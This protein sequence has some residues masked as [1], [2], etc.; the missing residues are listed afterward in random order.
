[1]L[2]IISNEKKMGKEENSYKSIMKRISA[3][4]G[5]QLLNI[6][7]TLVRGKFVAIFLG[8][9]GMG[10]SSLYT[11]SSNTIQQIGSLGLNLA[12]VKEV[13]ASKDDADKLPHILAVAL[14]L[15]LLSSLFGAAICFLLS[16][17]LSRWTFGDSTHTSGFMFLSVAVALATGG[18]GLLSILQGIGAVKELSKASLVGGICGL[19]FGVP[20][21]YFFGT[22]GIVPAMILLFL[23]MFIFYGLSLKK[24]IPRHRITFNWH[25]HSPLVRKIIAIGLILLI[26]NLA[27]TLTGYI[28]NAFIRYAGGLADVGLFQAANSITNQYMGVVLSALALDY[29]PRLSA[30]AEDLREMRDIVNRQTE[31]VSLI[32]APLVLLLMASAPIVIYLLLSSE[33]M[34]VMPLMRWMGFGMVFQTLNFPLGYIFI[35]KEDK[36]VYVWLEV[37]LSNILWILTSIGCYYWFGLIGLGVSLVARA[38]IELPIAYLVARKRYGYSYD[39]HTLLTILL[40]VSIAAAG[41][42][43]SFLPEIYAYI[44]MSLLTLTSAIYSFLKI[45]KKLKAEKES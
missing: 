6:F 4:G 14:R 7:L 17:L 9:A 15:I 24:Y 19:L 28:I 29:F 3:F 10:V 32:I 25:L 8:P 39:R 21:Y 40:T 20:L 16:P 37:V 23:S 13:A 18:A 2:I 43:C 31:I 26:G 27:G 12:L 35:A 34:P 33:F 38:A 1:M 41:F 44:S 45:R 22:E 5:V 36:R 11:S 42:L 30:G